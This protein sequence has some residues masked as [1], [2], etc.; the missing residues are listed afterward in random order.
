[1]QILD[2]WKAKQ[3]FRDKVQ[4]LEAKNDK[5]RAALRQIMDAYTNHSP[6]FMREIARKA[7]DE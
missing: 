3:P 6:F 5:L 4:L 7:L 1:M 2:T